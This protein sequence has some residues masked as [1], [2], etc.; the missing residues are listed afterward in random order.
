MEGDIN[1]KKELFALIRMLDEPE[2]DL[3]DSIRSNIESYGVLAL[4]YL[5]DIAANFLNDVQIR[6]RAESIIQKIRFNE[7][8]YKLNKWK[9]ENKQN[10]IDAW[11]IVEELIFPDIEYNVAIEKFNE[12]SNEIWLKENLHLNPLKKI[13]LINEIL[14][15]FYSFKVSQKITFDDNFLLIKLLQTFSC[16]YI[17]I[18]MLYLAIAQKLNYPVFGQ[19][20]E[21]S[22]LLSWVN[23]KNNENFI[24]FFEEGK[25][26]FYITPFM[27]GSVFN[28]EQMNYY[29][30]KNNIKPKPYFFKPFTNTDVI[31][32]YIKE[33]NKVLKKRNF[34][35]DLNNLLNAIIPE[36]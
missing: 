26:L 23:V 24:S 9:K 8:Y 10:I 3:F 7:T 21:D 27:K 4:P 12:I 13:E 22:F 35:I 18:T 28:E 5:E 19:F 33:L 31:S 30:T 25:I 20:I 36:D 17:T 14:F 11:I 2:Q 29:L 1:V 34:L 6:N 15:D 32:Y 16:N